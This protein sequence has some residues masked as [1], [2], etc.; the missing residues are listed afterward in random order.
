MYAGEAEVVVEKNQN[1][2]HDIVVEVNINSEYRSTNV[3]DAVPGW[4]FVD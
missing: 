4:W 1:E 3:G 2:S